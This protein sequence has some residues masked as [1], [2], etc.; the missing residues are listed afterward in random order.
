MKRVEYKTLC[1]YIL[2]HFN[3]NIYIHRKKTKKLIHQIVNP[4]QYTYG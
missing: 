1:K 4:S 3:K 2:D